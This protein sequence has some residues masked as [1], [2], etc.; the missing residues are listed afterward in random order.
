MYLLSGPNSNRYFPCTDD[1]PYCFKHRSFS[2]A[3]ICRVGALIASIDGTV[4]L[5]PADSVVGNRPYFDR[6]DHAIV[7]SSNEIVQAALSR[8]ESLAKGAAYDDV[9]QASKVFLHQLEV[10]K[11]IITK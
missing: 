6:N 9:R 5:D 1:K 7:T 4:V 10:F 8:V 3:A 2:S 11:Q